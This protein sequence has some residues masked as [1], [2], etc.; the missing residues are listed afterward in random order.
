[1]SSQSESSLSTASARRT[2]V[3]SGLR[4]SGWICF[5]VQLILGIVSSIILLFAM[6]VLGQE[7]SQ[8]SNAGIGG[9]LLFAIAGLL[10][11]AFSIY[12]AFYHTR[13]GR[14]LKSPNGSYPSRA[15]TLKQ[16]RITMISN[17]TGMALTLIGSE[18]VNGVLLAKTLAQPRGFFD[19][20]TNLRD[21]IQPL[22]IFI[23]LANTH[24]AV[25]HFVGIIATIWLIERIN[26]D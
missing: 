2:R 17:L 5:W 4:R 25:A 19:A 24:A 1:M 20:S 10:A 14:E 21:F 26:K 6:L 8:R 16:M 15:D 12:R 13:L 11:L 18:A 22:D 7:S 23:V 3:S 9:G